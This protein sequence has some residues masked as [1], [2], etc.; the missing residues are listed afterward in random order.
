MIPR[1]APG[2]DFD[3][4]FHRFWTHFGGPGGSKSG[5]TAIRKPIKKKVKKTV[6]QVSQEE[7]GSRGV[8]HSKGLTPDTS[9]HSHWAFYHSTSCRKGTVADS[10]DPPQALKDPPCGLGKHIMTTPLRALGACWRSFEVSLAWFRGHSR[11][12]L[13]S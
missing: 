3:S 13:G 9:S 6:S 8:R 2:M 10:K 7:L 1:R 12:M 4:I 5:Q 11:V